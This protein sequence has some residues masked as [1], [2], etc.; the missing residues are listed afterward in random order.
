MRMC[1]LILCFLSSVPVKAEEIKTLQATPVVTADF[2]H[3][4]EIY[5]FG[6]EACQYV[7]GEKIYSER[8]VL[9]TQMAPIP[10]PTPTKKKEK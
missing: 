2:K 6:F 3:D 9:K 5:D 10:S 7:R 8:C 1:L 4:L